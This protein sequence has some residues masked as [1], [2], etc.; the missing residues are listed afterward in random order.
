[1][2]KNKRNKDLIFICKKCGH[3]LYIIEGENWI[4]K[5]KKLDCPNCGEEPEEN[6][7]FSDSGNW[8]TSKFNKI[9]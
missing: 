1:M 7:I 2:S 9:N 6:W 3:Y 8:G 5:L 4:K